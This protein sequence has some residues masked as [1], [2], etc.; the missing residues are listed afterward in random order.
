M[1]RFFLSLPPQTRPTS[2][3][4][5]EYTKQLIRYSELPATEFWQM[6]SIDTNQSI[7][8]NIQYVK[9]L[10][11]G[12][13]ESLRIF[14]SVHTPLD[15]AIEPTIKQFE[16]NDDVP[17]YLWKQP[18]DAP[19]ILMVHGLHL[20]KRKAGF[21][22]F[23][24]NSFLKKGYNVA[25][26]IQPYHGMRSIHPRKQFFLNP[27]NIPLTIEA[28][29]QAVFDV[30]KTTCLLQQLLGTTIGSIGT[31]LGAHTLMM[32]ATQF[33]SLDYRVFNIPAID[34]NPHFIKRRII[35]PFDVDNDLHQ[36]SANAMARI[37]PYNYQPNASPD[38]MGLLYNSNDLVSPAPAIERLI[39][40]WSIQQV[41]ALQGGHFTNWPIKKERMRFIEDFLK[42]HTMPLSSIE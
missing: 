3:S 42:K 21:F 20:G 35:L 5:E 38:T 2:L 19:T 37:A 17:L 39:N 6:P 10:K 14:Q 33:N 7:E 28:V 9:Q 27:G 34:F 24:R 8:N 40:S 25:L 23:S 32:H 16:S 4:K 18:T 1:D 30:E 31:S 36:A 12:I 11:N 41:L 26:L 15:L 29:R 13:E 22:P